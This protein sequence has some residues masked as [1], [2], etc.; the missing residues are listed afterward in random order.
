MNSDMGHMSHHLRSL[1]SL[2]LFA[3][4]EKRDAQ[5]DVNG[6]G[7]RSGNRS[8]KRWRNMIERSLNMIERYRR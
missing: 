1:F 5:T 2:L 7:H 3:M 8:D 4:Y 6:D